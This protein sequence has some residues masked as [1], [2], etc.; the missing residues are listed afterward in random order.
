[1][2]EKG[3]APLVS[4]RTSKIG[5]QGHLAGEHREVALGSQSITKGKVLQSTRG[6]THTGLLYHF[7]RSF[8]KLYIFKTSE[9]WL[10]A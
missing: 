8:S 9:I 5:E 10:A 6:S 2:P 1:M 7:L 4:T 3:M